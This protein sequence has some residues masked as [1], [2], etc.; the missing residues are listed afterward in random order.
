LVGKFLLE[1]EMDVVGDQ[2]GVED[3]NVDSVRRY[4]TM[5]PLEASD[6]SLAGAWSRR[7]R[8]EQKSY[9][10]SVPQVEVKLKLWN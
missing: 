7:V 9:F 6:R 4:G 3:L 1:G 2:T 5:T 10:G 8:L